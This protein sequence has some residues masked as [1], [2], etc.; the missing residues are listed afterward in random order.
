MHVRMREQLADHGRVVVTDRF[1]DEPGAEI[2]VECQVDHGLAA[3]RAP[4]AGDLVDGPPDQVVVAL[5]HHVAHHEPTGAES[6]AGPPGQRVHL[7]DQCLA[8]VRHGG[9]L[10]GAVAD[11]GDL[12]PGGHAQQHQ[13]AL[14]E[15][16]ADVDRAGLHLRPHGG[17]AGSCRFDG[18]HDPHDAV[19]VGVGVEQRRQRGGDPVTQRQVGQLLDAGDRQLGVVELVDDLQDRVALAEHGRQC[20]E[21]G[22][23]GPPARHRAVGLV[24]VDEA[25]AQADRAGVE[26]HAQQVGHRG[27][28]VGGR[29]PLLGLGAHH[30]HPQHGVTDERRHVQGDVLG[31][32]VEPAAEPFPPAPVDAGIEG[33]FG[34]LLDQAEHAAERI[35]LLGPQRCQRQRA[36]AGHHG[37]DAV[38]DRR[39]GVRVEAEL[40]VVVGVG[41]DE[42]G[43]DHTPGGVEHLARLAGAAADGD[44]LAVV[45]RHVAV[46]AGQPRAIDDEPVADDE[47]EHDCPLTPTWYFSTWYVPN[48]CRSIAGSTML[49]GCPTSSS[50][51]LTPALSS[52]AVQASSSSEM[53]DV[54]PFS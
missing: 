42:P 4:L 53:V 40:R 46:P 38:L 31:E 5:V 20:V 23:C 54:P 49:H 2:L 47:I 22:R 52:E 8:L 51:E 25:G 28:L 35:P 39:K 48:C 45:D 12:P 18:A 16:E 13:A 33:R 27:H 19:V 43:G 17:A 24:D 30:V 15:R 10:L 21:L 6:A 44:H 34:H 3:R 1:A 32:R 7:V 36:V 11:R 29:R 14:V 26:T 41:V 50:S 37:G 9:Q